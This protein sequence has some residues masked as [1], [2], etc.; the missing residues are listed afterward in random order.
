MRVQQKLRAPG[1]RTVTATVPL[2]W[3]YLS[4]IGRPSHGVTVTVAWQ[5]RCQQPWKPRRKLPASE[6]GKTT[7]TVAIAVAASRIQ[8]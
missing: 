1:R 2:R 4:R 3:P 5:Y 7:V 6:T 8:T